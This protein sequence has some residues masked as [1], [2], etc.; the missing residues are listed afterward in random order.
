M[1]G[2][3][4]SGSDRNRLWLGGGVA[5]GLLVIVG[6]WFLLLSPELSAT[7]DTRDQIEDAQLQ[8]AKLQSNIT[9]LKAANAN[10]PTLVTQLRRSR[11][12]L[13]VTS[14][15]TTFTD[16]LAAQAAAAKVTITSIEIGRAH[17]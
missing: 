9:T 10:L 12:Q 16:Q 13:P 2:P 15:F 8:N 3:E 1:S 14:G 17:V 11:Q 4:L 6:G 5:V 7:S